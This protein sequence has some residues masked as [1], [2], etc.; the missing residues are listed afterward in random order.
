[1]S[2]SRF[3]ELLHRLRLAAALSQSELA[4]R[5]GLHPA[6]I[7]RLERAARPPQPSPEA[8]AALCA[9]L[10]ADPDAADALFHA[11]GFCPPSLARL[12]EWEPALGAL[13]RRLSSPDLAEDDRVELVRLLAALARCYS[14]PR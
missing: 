11:A 4:R 9:G 14:S 7:N 5:A 6:H 10:D 3:G 12:A 1:M 2:T 13:A 8:V